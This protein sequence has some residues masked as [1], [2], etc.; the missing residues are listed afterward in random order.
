MTQNIISLNLTDAQLQAV[1]AA[2]TELETQ[3]SGLIA[4]TLPQKRSLRKMGEKSEAFC[5]QALRVLEQNPQMAPPNVVAAGAIDDLVAID[6]LR[7][8]MVRLSRLSERA[9]DTDIALGSD[10]MSTSLQVY[11]LLKLTGGSEGLESLRRDLG[12]RFARSAK[13]VEAKAA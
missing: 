12:T 9:S 13:P 8:R 5:R 3:L 11:G 10:V 7:P 4:L 2:L 1:D 6:R